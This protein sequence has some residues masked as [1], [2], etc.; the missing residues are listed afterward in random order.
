MLYIILMCISHFM[1]FGN[2]LLLAVYFLFILDYGNDV[3]Q[4]ANLSSYSSSNGLWSS[5]TTRNINNAFGPE[6]ANEHSAQWWLKKCYKEGENLEDEYSGQL[7]EVDSDN[8]EPSSKLIP[9]ITIWE[10]VKEL[11]VNHSTVIWH[12]KQIERWKSLVSG[13]L[14]S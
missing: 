10:F 9:F 12:L 8:W 14:M 6:T 11:N 4:K 7:S 5:K 13:C 2:D 1:F 3:R